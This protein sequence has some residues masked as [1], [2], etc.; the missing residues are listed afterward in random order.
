M[1][2]YHSVLPGAAEELGGEFRTICG[3]LNMQHQKGVSLSVSP[4]EWKRLLAA[5]GVK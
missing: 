5:R 3:N 4:E 2:F 1:S